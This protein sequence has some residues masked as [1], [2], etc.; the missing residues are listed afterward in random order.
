MELRDKEGFSLVEV[1]IA[2]AVLAILTIPIL[3]Y[4]TNASVNSARGKNIQKANLVAQS[5]MEQLNGC[6]TFEQVENEITATPGAI[7]GADLWNIT[8]PYTASFKN[9]VIEKDISL[10]GFDYHAKVSFDYDYD[11][12]NVS[13]DAIHA[14][15]NGYAEPQLKEVYSNTNVVMA[16]SDQED[17]AVSNFLY[18]HKSTPVST[19][20]DGMTRTL[21]IDVDESGTSFDAVYTIVGYYLYSYDGED[22]KAVLLNTKIEKSKLEN[23]YLFYEPMQK[24]LDQVS[25]GNTA[26]ETV[27]VKLDNRITISDAEKIN[28]YFICQYPGS[29]TLKG[30]LQQRYSLV[31]D[32]A[33]C[34]GNY[35]NAKYFTNNIKAPS[36][37]ISDSRSFVTRETTG[38]RIAKLKVEVYDIRDLTKPLVT[39]DTSKG[40]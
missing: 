37:G 10:D 36:I 25:G 15:F 32:V 14:D 39:L 13:G 21:C 29:D 1:V 6:E 9:M 28:F 26:T 24:V 4:F 7:G 3:A 40:E 38:K 30:Y 22:Y 35:S 2:V 12:T 31:F 11:T 16:E 17:E 20:R 27:H 8:T 5:V 18:S 34:S 19:I 23:V 33:S